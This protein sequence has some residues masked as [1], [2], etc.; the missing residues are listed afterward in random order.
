VSAT[1][2]RKKAGVFRPKPSK[3]GGEEPR[4]KRKKAGVF[5][6]KPSEAGGESPGAYFLYARTLDAG[7][8]KGS[9]ERHR[10]SRATLESS[11]R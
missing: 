5:R 4:W 6:P 8:A 3:A 10:P 9:A 7:I 11:S 1:A 2:K